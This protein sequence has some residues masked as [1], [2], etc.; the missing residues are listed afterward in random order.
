MSRWRGRFPLPHQC[1]DSS[2][3]QHLPDVRRRFAGCAQR[4]QTRAVL[5]F[6]KLSA[7]RP[8][9]QLVVA[10]DRSGQA[11][12]SLQDAL[13]GGCRE[14]ISTAHHMRHALKR[15]VDG[16]RKMIA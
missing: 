3:A 7:I 4:A 5:A 8:E 11:E 6:R 15:V 14:K 10:V 9:D 12:Q 2:K 16:H 13:H 1:A